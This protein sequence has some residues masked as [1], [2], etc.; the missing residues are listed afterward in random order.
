[1]T[2]YN[3]LKKLNE[4]HGD[5]G[6]R[7]QSKPQPRT[8]DHFQ[9]DAQQPGVRYFKQLAAEVSGSAAIP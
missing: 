1:M 2:I 5:G 8:G 3:Y 9:Y 4:H 7:A 6:Q